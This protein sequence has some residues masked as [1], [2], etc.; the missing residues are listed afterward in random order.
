MKLG[1]P[2]GFDGGYGVTTRS[3]FWSI[4]ANNS[5]GRR[6]FGE[7]GYRSASIALRLRARSVRFLFGQRALICSNDIDVLRGMTMPRQRRESVAPSAH[8][9]GGGGRRLGYGRGA[10]ETRSGHH[11]I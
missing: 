3:G 6:T 5:F 10:T 4:V 8:P 9:N 11:L 2:A 7:K 1:C